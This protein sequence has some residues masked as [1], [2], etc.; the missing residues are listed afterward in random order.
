MKNYMKMGLFGLG[1]CVCVALM[2][3]MPV[4]AVDGYYAKNVMFEDDFDT[5]TT[6]DWS[7]KWDSGIDHDWFNV[8]YDALNVQI[9][10]IDFGGAFGVEQDRNVYV[11]APLDIAFKDNWSLGIWTQDD[12]YNESVYSAFDFYGQY[13]IFTQ[14]E[15]WF[16]LVD[17]HAVGNFTDTGYNMDASAIGQVGLFVNESE[18]TMAMWY[19]DTTDTLQIE[20]TSITYEQGKWYSVEIY[21]NPVNKLGTL[22]VTDTVTGEN[23]SIV[24]THIRIPQGG[25]MQMFY[26]ADISNPLLAPPDAIS[27]RDGFLIDNV[28]IFTY[29]FVP[30]HIIHPQEG[31]VNWVNYRSVGT[32]LAVVGVA[33]GVVGVVGFAD[34]TRAVVSRGFS[35]SVGAI[36][37]VAGGLI[38]LI[39]GAIFYYG[40]S[41]LPA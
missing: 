3:A 15:F 26:G 12:V 21:Y 19:Y 8:S 28:E 11:E 40:G 16:G 39:G 32:S 7:N 31:D 13:A 17:D 4:N 35:A 34:I 23:D 14:A 10:Y 6:I 41:I 37:A 27:K 36:P 29:E 22:N 5:R 25:L 38:T 2:F 30:T 20:N 33:T 18:Q 1:A 24:A 9:P